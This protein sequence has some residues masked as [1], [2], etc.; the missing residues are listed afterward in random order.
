MGSGRRIRLLYNA[1][2]TIPENA[3]N[4]DPD[5]VERKGRFLD[6][7]QDQQKRPK[8]V[9]LPTGVGEGVGRSGGEPEK[10]VVGCK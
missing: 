8:G 7:D 2:F 6:Q 5:D 9:V 1:I 3:R 4:H 10:N